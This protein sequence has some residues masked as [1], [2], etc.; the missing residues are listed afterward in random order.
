L[1]SVHRLNEEAGNFISTNTTVTK[2]FCGCEV[3]LLIKYELLQF[4]FSAEKD[5]LK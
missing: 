2:S 4:V 1:T 5:D 3:D